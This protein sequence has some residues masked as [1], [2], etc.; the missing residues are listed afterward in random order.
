M[1]L[2][3]KDEKINK[4]NKFERIKI[5]SR[6]NFHHTKIIKKLL[7]KSINE[8]DKS[9]NINL[10]K[11]D[12]INYSNYI[13][14]IYQIFHTHEIKIISNNFTNSDYK[15]LYNE[16]KQIN[17]KLIEN[18]KK[19]KKEIVS[20]L[21][22]LNKKDIIIENLRKELFQYEIIFNKNTNKGNLTILKKEIKMLEKKNKNLNEKLNLINHNINDIIVFN[23]NYQIEKFSFDLYSN[24]TIEKK[25]NE[26]LED[27]KNLSN[28]FYL[29]NN[30]YYS[31]FE[32]KDINNNNKFSNLNHLYY[33]LNEKYKKI[34]KE[35][36]NLDDI[37]LKQEE[38]INQLNNSLGIMKK[39]AF[40]HSNNFLGKNFDDSQKL[41]DKFINK[42]ESHLFNSFNNSF[43]NS[44]NNNLYEY[45][46]KYPTIRLNLNKKRFIQNQL[47]KNK[48]D[49]QYIEIN[50]ILNKKM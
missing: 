14:G 5:S 29:K 8:N 16:Q 24:F 39:M 1:T 33:I 13:K 12:K 27:N 32:K 44:F 30:K 21:Q 35:K 31:N 6:N 15:Q 43:S 49:F 50:K 17:E 38:K 40:Y 41:N 48:S 46:E 10:I 3:N 37:I 26:L 34:K 25:G 42:F 47:K 28:T 4:I 36:Y 11:N 9:T 20:M 2:Y 23:K 7:P 18:E 22:E 19:N 45:K